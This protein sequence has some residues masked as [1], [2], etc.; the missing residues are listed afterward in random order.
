LAEADDSGDEVG[1]VDL[2]SGMNPR[3][4]KKRGRSDAVVA[5]GNAAGADVVSYETKEKDRSSSRK[6]AKRSNSR[7]A[8]RLCK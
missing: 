3:K 8:K 5:N 6:R 2:I 4:E 1:N 7:Q